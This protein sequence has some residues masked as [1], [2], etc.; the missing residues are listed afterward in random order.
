MNSK[1]GLLR[2]LKQLIDRRSWR[3]PLQAD[4]IAR[5]AHLC[6]SNAVSLLAEAR[7]LATN[8]HS[9]RALAL[10]VLALE[11]LAKPP[12]LWELTPDDGE[13]KW[14]DF[15]TEQFSRHSPK[16]QVIGQYG[17]FLETMGSSVFDLSLGSS[18]IQVLDRLKQW[19]FYVDCIDGAFQSPEELA[20]QLPALLDSLFAAAEERADSFAQFHSTAGMSTRAYKERLSVAD[21]PLMP[22]ALWPPVVESE[23]EVLGVLLSQASRY[24]L[25]QPPDYYKFGDAYGQLAEVLDASILEPALVSLVRLGYARSRCHVLAISA[26]RGF[27]MMKLA[28]HPLSKDRRSALLAELKA[29]NGA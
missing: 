11:E 24:S 29:E 13:D 21:P 1:S 20:R 19:G 6:W 9:A 3:K 14:R 15:W 23:A 2:V 25:S 27:L 26:G 16:Q 28:L 10:T 8:S 18:T 12:L 17:Q 7:L 4:E 22:G 5:G